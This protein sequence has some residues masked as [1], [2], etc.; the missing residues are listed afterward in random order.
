[1]VAAL[2]VMII[3]PAQAGPT[4]EPVMPATDDMK[5]FLA[6]VGAEPALMNPKEFGDYL[7]VDTERW[8]KVVKAANLK[9]D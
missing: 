7:K 5:K 2:T 6:S 8:A 1:M 3:A 9:I 4:A